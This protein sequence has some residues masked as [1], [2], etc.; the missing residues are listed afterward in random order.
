MMI[1]LLTRIVLTIST[2]ASR[3]SHYEIVNS[4]PICWHKL[5][6]WPAYSCDMIGLGY[7]NSWWIFDLHNT[8]VQARRLQRFLLE[9]I[10][11]AYKPTWNQGL[12]F[13]FININTTDFLLGTSADTDPGNSINPITPPWRQRF[14]VWTYSVLQL[15]RWGIE[16]IHLSSS[17]MGCPQWEC[18]SF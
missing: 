7:G 1:A 13:N 14:P 16:S 8:F 17:A 10:K 12:A 9:E 15:E 6:K 4:R 5:N 18:F 11:L 3:S 2:Y